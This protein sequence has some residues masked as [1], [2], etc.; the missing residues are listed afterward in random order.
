M[1]GQQNG[2]VFK[3][4]VL[5]G[6][7]P[8]DCWE[9]RGTINKNT[10]YG[11]KTYLGKDVLAHRWVYEMLL[12]PIPDGLVVNH[13]C[14]NRRCVNPHHLEVVSQADNC[15]HGNG[16]ILNIEIVKEIKAAKDNKKWGDATR[17]AK[18]YGVSNALIHDIWNGRAWKEVSHETAHRH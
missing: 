16:S 18:K 5:L 17:L 12:G 7:S 11:K 14:S 8:D 9:W 3:P 10:G 4:L 2:R 15:R 6:S 13:K 1:S